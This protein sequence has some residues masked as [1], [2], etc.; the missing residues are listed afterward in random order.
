LS[1]GRAEIN[2]IEGLDWL[3]GLMAIGIMSYHYFS[4]KFGAIELE[5]PLGRLGIY[6][7]SIF[8]VLRE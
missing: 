8:Y 5:N 2:R 1:V 4:W 7:V 3:R 6:G